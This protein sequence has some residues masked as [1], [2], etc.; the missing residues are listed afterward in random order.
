MNQQLYSI[1]I[2]GYVLLD[3]NQISSTMTKTLIKGISSTKLS[4]SSWHSLG[5]SKDAICYTRKT[6]SRC[7][8]NGLIFTSLYLIR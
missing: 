1:T 7:L 3:E 6:I 2:K 4:G 8:V 5:S